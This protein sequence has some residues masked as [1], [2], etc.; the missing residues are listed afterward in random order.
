MGPSRD[1]TSCARRSPVK[2]PKDAGSIPATST[3]LGAPVRG[4]RGRGAFRMLAA[5][6]TPA[7]PR[8]GGWRLEWWSG[9]PHGHLSS[10]EGAD[11]GCFVCWPR[12]RAPR[13]R[14]PAAAGSRAVVTSSAWSPLSAEGADEGAFRMLAAGPSPADPRS[15]GWRFGWWSD[16]HSLA[17]PVRGKRGRGRFVCWPRGRAPRPRSVMLRAAVVWG[18]ASGPGALAA[19][20]ARPSSRPQ[21]AAG[22]RRGR[23]RVASVR[24]RSRPCPWR[25]S[26]PP[27]RLPGRGRAVLDA[28]GLPSGGGRQLTGPGTRR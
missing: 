15:G 7:D 18:S 17:P 8:S 10:A 13:T 12:G 6:A 21:H 26:V 25:G 3:S 9:A 22:A 11:K 2:P 23:C 24:R 1:I 28:D 16:V 27:L 19:Q 5:G 20:R 14:V 4:K